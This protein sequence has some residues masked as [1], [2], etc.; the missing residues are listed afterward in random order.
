[1]KKKASGKYRARL[2]A[3]GFEQQDG[4]HYDSSSIASPVV[5]DI[6]IRIILIISIMAMWFNYMIDH[7]GAF[8]HG[9]FST[10]EKNFL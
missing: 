7:I 8:L 1:M 3:R 5:N 6:T 2:T 9:E 10:K 4:I